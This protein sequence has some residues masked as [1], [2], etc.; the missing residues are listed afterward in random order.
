MKDA[1]TRDFHH[2]RGEGGAEQHPDGGDDHRRAVGGNPAAE[3]GIQKVRSVVAYPD[4]KIKT[5]KQRQK[6]QDDEVEIFHREGARRE[7][8][9]RQSETIAPQ[10]DGDL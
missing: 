8:T 3:S 6:R 4:K 2:P 9:I 1:G 5:G 10:F 7:G